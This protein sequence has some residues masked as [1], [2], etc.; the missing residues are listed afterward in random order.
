MEWDLN[1]LVANLPAV[2]FR[3]Y[4]DGSIDLFDRKVETMTGFTKEEFE[5][6]HVKW[7]DLIAPADRDGAKK[8][9]LNALKTTRNY[10]REYRITS[11]AGDAVWV[12]ERSQ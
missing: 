7:T 6:R 8:A 1:S 4:A 10:T 11:K 9:L 2:F 12:H 3:G 5:S